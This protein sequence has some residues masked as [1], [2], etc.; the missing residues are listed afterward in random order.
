MEGEFPQP[1]PCSF[2]AHP[3]AKAVA[4]SIFCLN[5]HKVDNA[6]VLC[7]FELP[8]LSASFLSLIFCIPSR[9]AHYPSFVSFEP[10]P[11]AACMRAHC[12]HSTK[13]SLQKS[14]NLFPP[15]LRFYRLCRRRRGLPPS[16]PFSSSLQRAKLPLRFVVCFAMQTRRG[17]MSPND[18]RRRRQRRKSVRRTLDK[19]LASINRFDRA[20]S[21]LD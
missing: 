7:H 17:R 5:I 11:C 4:E 3:F 21:W 14:C 12:A 16:P 9:Q 1:I 20:A 10:A 18:W 19:F 13:H 2:V 8:P 6:K 15:S